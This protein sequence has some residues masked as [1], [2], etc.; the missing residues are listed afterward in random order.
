MENIKLCIIV[1]RTLF[2]VLICRGQDN[3]WILKPWNL[4][5]GMDI[6]ITDNLVQMIKL[7]QAGP[8]VHYFFFLCSLHT[9]M[10]HTCTCACILTRTHSHMHM[11][12]TCTQTDSIQVHHGSSLI[13]LCRRRSRQIRYPL[14]TTPSLSETTHHVCV[15]CI[16]AQIC[17]QVRF[18]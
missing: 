14:C 12:Y 4:G 16:L 10:L 13:Q 17:Q 7:A 6:H 5:R 8:K 15:R 11:C 1:L 9:C 3:L 2:V 18:Y